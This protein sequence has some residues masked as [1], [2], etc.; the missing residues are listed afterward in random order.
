MRPSDWLLVAVATAAFHRAQPPAVKC[1]SQQ[2]PE[3]WCE[4]GISGGELC[5]SCLSSVYRLLSGAVSSLA[6]SALSACLPASLSATGQLMAAS[7]P[8][9]LPTL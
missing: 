3:Y 9:A 7:S 4:R 2:W 8:D 6:L 5:V 1:C